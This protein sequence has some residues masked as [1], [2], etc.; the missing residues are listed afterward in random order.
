M[1]VL[2]KKELIIQTNEE[3]KILDK[4]FPDL[5]TRNLPG[6]KISINYDP[7]KTE[8]EKILRILEK[9]KVKINDILTKQ[10]DLEEIFKHLITS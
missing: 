9:N 2:S 3:I 10:P 4:I 8:I 6:N 7:K 1:T 5:E